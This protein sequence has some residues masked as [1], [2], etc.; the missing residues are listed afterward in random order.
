[1]LLEAQEIYWARAGRV[2]ERN[3]EEGLDGWVFA[4]SQS[5][6]PDL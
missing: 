5:S 3:W 2:G 1:M 4:G 6:Q